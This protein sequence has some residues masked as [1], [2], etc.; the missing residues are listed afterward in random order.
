[1]KQIALLLF[2]TFACTAS[3]KDLRKLVLKTR[4]EMKCERCS[5]NIKDKMKFTKGIKAL[6]PNHVTKLVTIIFDAEKGSLQLIEKDFRK[7][8]YQIEVVSE[9][10]MSEKK[11]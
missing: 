10:K 4:P 2:I 1:M 3:A 9:E 6:E 5:Q 7:A 8:G 11:D